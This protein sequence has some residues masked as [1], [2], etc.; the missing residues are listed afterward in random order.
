MRTSRALLFLTLV[1]STVTVAYGDSSLVV[2]SGDHDCF[3]LGGTC[4]DGARFVTDLGGVFFNNYQGPGDGLYTDSWASF[5]SVSFNYAYSVPV[6]TTSAILRTKIAGIHD[7]YTSDTYSV[8]FNG[9]SI[10]IIPPN[11][12]TSS[13]EEVLSYSWLVPLG[14][15][16]GHDTVSW[17]G[18]AGDGYIIDYADLTVGNS[19][20]PEPGTILLLGTGAVGL[21]GMIRRKLAR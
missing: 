12:S 16:T 5:G 11:F 18:T 9:T 4:P 6:G 2:P 14:L 7:I 3:G 19:A 21:A 20:V 15:L 1:L 10:G 17:S 13:A 8:L